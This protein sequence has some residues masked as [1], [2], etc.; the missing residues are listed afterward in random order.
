MVTNGI[1]YQDLSKINRVLES[2]NDLDD[3]LGTLNSETLEFLFQG[4]LRVEFSGNTDTWFIARDTIPPYPFT[5][6][7]VNLL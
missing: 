7:N 4:E 2:L 5:L 1:N 3:T 6:Q